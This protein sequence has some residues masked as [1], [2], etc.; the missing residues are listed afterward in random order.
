MPKRAI[1]T[2]PRA[3]TFDLIALSIFSSF[4][5]SFNFFLDPNQHAFQPLN[6]LISSSRDFFSEAHST[7]LVSTFFF[8]IASSSTTFFLA[9][10]TNY[11]CSKLATPQLITMD[12]AWNS[13]KA[14]LCIYGDLESNRTKILVYHH[15]TIKMWPPNG[16]YDHLEEPVLEPLEGLRV[17][18]K[19]KARVRAPQ[20]R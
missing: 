9:S 2:S 3:V 17:P 10:S 11:F 8:K 14:S 18:V 13:N 1:S 5:S 12:R 15:H 20:Q 19:K 7:W 16:G 6:F 4:F